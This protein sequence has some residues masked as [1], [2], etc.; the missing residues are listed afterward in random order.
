MFHCLLAVLYLKSW[1]LT[2]D[3]LRY[4]YKIYS[5]RYCITHRSSNIK[6]LC[7]S[8]GANFFTIVFTVGEL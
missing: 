2:G 1:S 7:V 5:P 4:G 3:L 8:V 6:Y